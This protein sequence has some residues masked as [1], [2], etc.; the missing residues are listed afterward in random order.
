MD[1]AHVVVLMLENRSFDSMLGR[2]RP[3]SAA[4]DGLPDGWANTW[5][6]PPN[7]AQT[8][9]AWND[10]ALTAAT[11]TIPDPDRGELHRHRG[12]DPGP[13]PRCA[14]GRVRRQLH[15][16]EAG[17]E[18]VRS[19]RADALLHPGQVPVLSRLATA[20]GVSDRWFAAAPCQTWP[21]RFFTHCGTAGGAVN[22][23]PERL[24]FAMPTV[25]GL[26]E[27]RAATGGSIS[28]TS[29]RR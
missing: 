17:G 6:D 26:L 28:M 18:A 12:A 13:V 2:P 22:N 20:F 9:P 3:A 24:P 29:R 19:A 23:A 1:I 14:D 11:A 27:Q 16:P 15:A 5:H 10:P 21:N 25:F 4:F 8:V 7:P